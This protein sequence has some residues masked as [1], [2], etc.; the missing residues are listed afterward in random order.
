MSTFENTLYLS[1]VSFERAKAQVAGTRFADLR[2]VAETG[3]TNA[4]VRELL[5]G[6]ASGG[7]PVVLVADH[8]TAGRGRLERSWEAPPGTS[9]LMTIG[10]PAD[11]LVARRRTLLTTALALSVT[12]VRPELT[13]KWPNDLVVPAPAGDPLGYRKLGGILAEVHHLDSAGQWALLGIGLN[14]NWPEIPTELQ[15]SATSLNQVVGAEVD[16]EEL[17]A[18]ILRSFDQVWLP[19]LERPEP[20]RD[21]HLAYRSRSATLGRQV[22]VELPDGQILGVATDVDDDGALVLTDDSGTT[23]TVTVGDVV[24]LRPVT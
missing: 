19:V 7:Q 13:I 24:H 22:R 23:R 20:P 5:A 14:V 18:G 8:Q 2:W 11:G 17:V 6:R 4:D 21:L 1:P 12:E 16:R 9:V 3:S 15:G 10:L